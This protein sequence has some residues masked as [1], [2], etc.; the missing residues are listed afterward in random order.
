MSLY[1]LDS[2]WIV[3]CLHGQASATQ[4]LLELAADGLALS[5]I[6]YG[7]LYQ[8]AYYARDPK[9]AIRGLRQFLRGK[10]LLPL[11]KGVVE[12]FGIVRGTLPR[13]LQ[14]Q[15]GDM[16]LLIAATALYHDLTLLTRNLRDIQHIP[17][18]KLY[19]TSP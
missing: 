7:E 19:Q 4:T 16:D 6:T 18:L 2:D 9:T 11:T 17:G 1:L 13:S 12:R 10:Q 8:G 15:I 14:Q 5:I 3:D